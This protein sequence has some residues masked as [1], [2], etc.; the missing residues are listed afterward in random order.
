MS[1]MLKALSLFLYELVGLR[2]GNIH[3]YSMS[4]ENIQ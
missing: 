1:A 2:E 4:S 3:G